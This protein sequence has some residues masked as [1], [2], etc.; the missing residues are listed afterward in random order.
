MR[1]VMTTIFQHAYLAFP[2]V[3]QGELSPVRDEEIARWFYFTKLRVY[4]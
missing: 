4:I 2:S 3:G 1:G